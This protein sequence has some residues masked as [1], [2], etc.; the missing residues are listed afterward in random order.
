MRTALVSVSPPARARLLRVCSPPKVVD[1]VRSSVTRREFERAV[2]PCVGGLRARA[3]RLA[4]NAADADDLLQE[5]LLRAWRFWPRYRDQDHCRAW[6]QCIM[7]NTFCSNCRSSARRRAQLAQ[8]ALERAVSEELEY[9]SAQDAQVAS[10]AAERLGDD[11]LASSLA[12]LKPEQREI[13]RLIDVNQRSYRE[14]ASALACPIGTVM[15]RLHRARA[16]LRAQLLA[17]PAVC[18]T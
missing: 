13:L 16:A 6:L 8:L 2:L 12:A 15:S 10:D 18:L 14:A 3:L 7:S 17:A 11:R 5:T 9:A 4:K 1:V